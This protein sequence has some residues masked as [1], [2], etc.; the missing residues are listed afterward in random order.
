[1]LNQVYCTYEHCKN[2][3]IWEVA[4]PKIAPTI[5]LEL[6]PNICDSCHQTKGRPLELAYCSVECL[7]RHVSSIYFLELCKNLEGKKDA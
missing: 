1:M 4:N 3:L 5:K 2:A 7:R 6:C